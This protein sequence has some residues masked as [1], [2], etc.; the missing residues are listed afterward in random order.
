MGTP[1]SAAETQRLFDGL[2]SFP[3]LILAV[4][5]GP[6]S[7]ALLMLAARWRDT[8]EQPPKLVAVTIDHGLR[9][10]AKTEAQA[11]A[12]LARRLGVAH[13]TLRWAGRKPKT[14]LQEAAR[15][16]RY[17]LLA[18]AARMAGARHVLTAHT[19]D[20]QS[21]TVLFRLIRGSGIS[22]LAGMARYAKL[23]A[24]NGEEILVVRVLLS[25]P[26]SRLIATLKAARTPY[27]DDPSNRDPRFTRARLRA[28]MPALAREGLTAQRLALLARRAQRAELALLTMA[29]QA[30]NR[31]ASGPWADEGPVRM[32]KDA[33][34]GLPEEIALQLLELAIDA[35]G[36]EGP[37]ELGKLESLHGALRC[38]AASG[39][40]RR[41]LAGAMV[42]LKGDKLLIERA[43]PRRRA[44]KRP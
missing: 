28:L 43:P 1:V 21:E 18:D 41:T 12:K 27:A 20:D 22:G 29:D 19:L 40:F 8:L 26:K 24:K 35:K 17:R 13:R 37:A 5:G 16:A 36:N 33:F 39:R 6:D 14:G 42:T 25:V 9:P 31:I 30:R 11:V 10:E 7:T 44:S 38:S 2:W 4:S 32:D 15:N 3:A 34:L 23:P